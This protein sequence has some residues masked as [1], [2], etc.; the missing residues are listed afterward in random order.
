MLETLILQIG[1]VHFPS[2]KNVKYDLDDKDPSFPIGLKDIISR[3]KLKT[4]FRS[5]Y[6]TLEEK[7]VDAALLMGDLTNIGSLKGFISCLDFITESLQI[8]EHKERDIFVGL[9]PGNHDIDRNLAKT[10][11][12]EDKFKLLEKEARKFGI[13]DFSTNTIKTTSVPKINPR[14]KIVLLNSCWGCGEREFIPEP[15]RD[16]IY[17]GLKNLID[18]GG[19][20]ALGAYY[21]RQL[22]TPAISAEHVASAVKEIASC[23]AH[24]IPIICAHH[25]LLPQHTTRLAPYTELVNS[26]SLR[27]SLIDLD[28][29]IIFLHGH[30]HE[31]PIEIIS[32]P[33]GGKLISISAPH[34]L[35]GYNLL[36][37][38][39]DRKGVPFICYIDKFRFDD[40]GILRLKNTEKVSLLKRKIRSTDNKTNLLYQILL[41][42]R[43][44]Y[45]DE[46]VEAADGALGL[47][48]DRDDLLELVELL[49]AD[50][51][52]VINNPTDPFNRWI[53]SANL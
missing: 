10:G 36:R 28:R 23:D 27:S 48:G 37:V 25:N 30:I 2:S 24:S 21:D 43:T 52:V 46:L 7:T 31:D 50:D 18:K 49:C 19:P 15:F 16:I 39:H 20:E 14:A 51:S 6:S 4:V 5:L 35:D 38:R 45:W 26:G 3:K 8:G 32:S 1:D 13:P 53:L 40:G 29:P 17:N 41:H 22:D 47:T 9:V 11:V 12:I 33:K 44:M 42:N 34:I